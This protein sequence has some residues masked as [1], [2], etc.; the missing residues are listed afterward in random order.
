MIPESYFRQGD[1]L[2]LVDVQNDFCPGGALPIEAGDRI[3]PAVN[4]WIQAA[5]K[6]GVPVFASRDWHPSAHL[7]FASEGGPWP[8]HCIQDTPGAGFHKDLKLPP[9]AVVV[10]KGV[11]FDHDQNSAFD[12]TGL[13]THL[14]RKGIR[15][16]LVAGLALDVCVLATAMDAL[17]S[18]FEVVLLSDATR[19]VSADNGAAAIQQMRQAGVQVVEQGDTAV[20]T[21]REGEE[22]CLKAPEWAEHQRFDDDDMGCDDGRAG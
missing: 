13:G 10:T 7:S 3:L 4:A 9:D 6:S 14:K 20:D 8:P 21:A 12:D 1:A 5:E 16:I 19:P 15:R 2:V 11:R 18:G 17:K 22:V